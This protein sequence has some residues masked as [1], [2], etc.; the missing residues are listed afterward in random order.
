MD[1]RLKEDAGHNYI[2]IMVRYERVR[3]SYKLKS[4]ICKSMLLNNKKYIK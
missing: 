2:R 1:G 4:T 3:S